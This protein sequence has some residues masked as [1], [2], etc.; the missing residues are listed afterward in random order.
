MKGGI[1]RSLSR[2]N[3]VVFRIILVKFVLKFVGFVGVFG[4]KTE[5]EKAGTERIFAITTAAMNGRSYACGTLKQFSQLRR[6]FMGKIS[7]K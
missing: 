2:K 4:P 1:P 5:L 6:F 3:T 7:S